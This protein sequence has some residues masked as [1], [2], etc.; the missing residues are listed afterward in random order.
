MASL[1]DKGYNGNTNLKKKGVSIEWDQEKLQEYLRCARDPKY[2][3]QK[4][5]KIVHVDHG[6]IP[7][8][9]YDYQEEIIDKITNGRRVV[10]NTS[11]QAGKTTTA[12]VVILHYILFNDHKTVA[13]LANK[14]DAAREIL[15]RIKIAFEA[16]PK[17]LQQG[18]I[19]WN[20]GSVEFE[21]GFV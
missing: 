10:V 17:W 8:D 21:N 3:A 5:I 19:E 12:V 6:L 9:L 7:I 20:K 14:G 2:F 11:R 16:L 4:Y 18:V 15:E 1:A 13:L